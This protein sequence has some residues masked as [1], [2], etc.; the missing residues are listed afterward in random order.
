M[1][2]NIITKKQLIIDIIIIKQFYKQYKLTEIHWINNNNNS[3][4][5]IIKAK[6][7]KILE[8]FV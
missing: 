5:I 6:L 1:K 8:I 3:I 4:N 2:L 7:N